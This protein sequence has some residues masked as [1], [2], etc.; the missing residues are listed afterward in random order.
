MELEL[1]K[2][3]GGPRMGWK[4]PLGGSE[5]FKESGALEQIK[6]RNQNFS[7]IEP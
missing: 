3:L 6:N 1:V 2:G 7:A 5:G 4:C